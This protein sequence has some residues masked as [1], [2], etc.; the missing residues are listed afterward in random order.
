MDFSRIFIIAEAGVNHNG[1]IELALQLID[2]AVAAGADAI[3]FQ[4]FL[5]EKL[6]SKYAA[7]ADYQLKS[8]SSAESQLEMLQKLYLDEDA[9]W[10]LINYC[11]NK[12]IRFLST[13]FDLESVDLLSRTFDLP[14]LKLASG[15]ITNA[16]LLLSAA[17]TG[18]AVILSTGMSTLGEVEA[19]LGVLAFGYTQGEAAPSLEAFQQAYISVEGQKALQE[20]VRLLHCT[21]E[22]PAAYEDVNLR[23]MDTLKAAFGLPVGLSDHTQGIAIPVAAAARGASII[24]KHFTLDCNLPGPDHKASLEPAE[25]ASMIRQI[26]QVEAA[27][28]TSLKRP[29]GAELKNKN[30]ARKSLVAARDIKQGELFT[31]ENLAVKRPGDGVSPMNYWEALGKRAEKDYVQD[32][33]VIL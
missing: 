7:K 22:Y 28:G 10:Q 14:L 15:E 19:A 33:L 1:S 5:P 29:V 3:K 17:R 24:E 31:P 13:P 8:T 25:L 32:E 30:V 21:T 9:H 11:R 12:G 6:V 18:K 16:P 27:L 26:R 4:T 2:T 20:K 23:M